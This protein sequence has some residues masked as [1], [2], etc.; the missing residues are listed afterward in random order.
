M[1]LLTLTQSASCPKQ[2]QQYLFKSV[3]SF[4]TSSSEFKSSI[5]CALWF[6]YLFVIWLCRR[7]DFVFSGS[8]SRSLSN[9]V[10]KLWSI[11]WRRCSSRWLLSPLSNGDRPN[12]S[13]L[14]F[15]KIGVLGIWSD[16]SDFSFS[17]FHSS[18]DGNGLWLWILRTTWIVGVLYSWMTELPFTTGSIALLFNVAS[19]SAS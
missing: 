11:S 5:V 15:S 7:Y 19:Q 4:W 6:V 2:S 1:P 13:D 10:K 14:N 16:I 9:Y 8:Y 18:F 3:R 12:F 17:I